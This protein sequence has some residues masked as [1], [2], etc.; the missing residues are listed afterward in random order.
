LGGGPEPRSYLSLTHYWDEEVDKPHRWTTQAPDRQAITR[1]RDAVTAQAVPTPA[2]PGD[3]FRP[4]GDEPRIALPKSSL[5]AVS[6][7]WWTFLV[8][9]AVGLLVAI[10]YLRG[11]RLAL[12][13]GVIIIL[14][15]LPGLQLGAALLTAIILAVT[16]HPNKGYQFWQLGKIVLGVVIGTLIG[17]GVMWA[18]FSGLRGR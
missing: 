14:L 18:M 16:A 13:G 2:A 9:T 6:L 7:F 1:D 12:V 10:G 3:S 4:S 11:D 17:L 8:L 5:S 15:I